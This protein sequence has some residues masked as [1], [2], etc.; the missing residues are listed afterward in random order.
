M[1][2]P[3]DLD[4]L[5]IF[6]HSCQT[7]EAGYSKNPHDADVSH[8]SSLPPCS[9]VTLINVSESNSKLWKKVMWSIFRYVW[10]NTLFQDRHLLVKQVLNP[11]QIVSDSA[12]AFLV[13]FIL[14]MCILWIWL[15]EYEYLRQCNLV[16]CRQWVSGITWKFLLECFCVWSV[17]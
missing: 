1:A 16:Y 7:S 2:A 6:E 13:V 11:S 4:R 15:L 14:F 12:R 10:S 17:W 8:C 9:P 5:F 3:S